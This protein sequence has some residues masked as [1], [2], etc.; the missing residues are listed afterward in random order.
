M[1]GH[2]NYIYYEGDN[3]YYGIILCEISIFIINCCKYAIF[4]LCLL[5]N[6]RFN[7]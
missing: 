5:L 3:N 7:D 1:E 4:A 2:M 6:P